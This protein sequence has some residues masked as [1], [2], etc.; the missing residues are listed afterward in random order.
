[1]TPFY[2][3]VLGILVTWRVTH[4]ISVETGPWS[5][6]EKLRRFADQCSHADPR[7]DLKPFSRCG[8]IA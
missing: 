8:M 1:M 3:P 6:F 2:W 7:N 4:L 5:I